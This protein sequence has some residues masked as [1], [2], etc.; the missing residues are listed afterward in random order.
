MGFKHIVS[1]IPKLRDPFVLVE[2]DTYYV[3]GSEWLCYKSKGDLATWEKVEGELVVTPPTYVTNNWAPEVHKYQN[4]YYMFTTYYSSATEHRGCTILKA[5]SPE[6]PFV[7]IT[8]GTVTP[9]G[10]DCIDGTFYVD[11]DGQP[12]MIFVHEWTCM[13]D[14]VGTMAAAKLSEDLTHFVSEPI[15]LFRADEPDWAANGVT[16][17]CFMHTL[18][19]GTLIMLW[20]N[21]EKDGYCEAI[22]RSDNGRL[23]GKW[24]HDEKL[25]YSKSLSGTPYDGGHGMLFTALD[26]QL[27]L[28]LHSPNTPVG[29]V[30]E[31]PV[32]IPVKEENGSLV[33]FFDG[34]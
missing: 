14:H 29:D 5:A 31:R 4:A 23:D 1:N 13:P 15:E 21:F 19:D 11:P 33:C 28:S 10:W 27:Y 30:M 32:F 16:D 34:E 2:G 22:V 7:E 3:Y 26:G 17:G 8:N 20:S 24:V 18:S 12:W 25:L 6:G 9:K